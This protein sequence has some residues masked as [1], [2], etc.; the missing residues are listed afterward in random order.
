MAKLPPIYKE[1]GRTYQA[2]TCRPVKQAVEQGAMRLRALARG[3]YP[4]RQLPARAL[5]GVCA[6]GFWDATK[7]QDWGLDWH[8]NEGIEL[9][10]L[11]SGS[12]AFGVEDREHLL[13]PDDLTIT[14]PWQPHHVGNPNVG[15]GRLHWLI[16]DVGMR[17]PHQQWKWPPWLVLA[18]E[19]LAELTVMLRQNEQPVW[20]T[21]ADVRRCFQRIARAVEADEGGDMSRLPLHLNELFVLV[22]EMFRQREI[23]LDESLQSSRRTVELFLADVRRNFAE[24]WTLK[25]MARQCG[26]GMTRF[27]HY[28]KQ[29]TNMTPMQHLSRCRVEQ[30]SKLLQ[31][32]PRMSVTDVAFDCGFSSSQYF[33]TVFRQHVGCSPRAFRAGR[34]P[35]QPQRT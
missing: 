17:R 11:E 19:D 2:D 32:R 15:V 8:R 29:I 12:L 27:V 30:A 28:C 10:F 5:R 35:C 20:R 26:L 13:R 3:T 18:E 25:D 9:T 24:P 6:V 22:L 23:P 14:R 7:P 1:H 21:N 4:G 16:L 31:E 33:A 34:A